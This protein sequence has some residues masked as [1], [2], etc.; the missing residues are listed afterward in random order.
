VVE[1]S[2]A[3]ALGLQLGGVNTYYGNRREDR[4][5]MGRGR[6]PMPSDI[7]RTTRLA[8]RVG[9]GALLTAVMW[10]LAGGLRR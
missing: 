10:C 4:A 8:Q 1:A 3:G 5:R 2:F 6:A 9:A 7:P